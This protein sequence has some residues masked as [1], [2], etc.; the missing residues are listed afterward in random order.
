[1]IACLTE[2]PEEGLGD[3]D[4]VSCL[5]VRADLVGDLPA[6]KVR[7]LLPRGFDGALLYTLRSRGEGGRF[8]G[9]REDRLARLTL[10]A[11]SYDFVD[12]EARVDLHADVL[13]RIAGESR[14]VSWHGASKSVGELKRRFDEMA[15]VKA[16][17]YKL[18]PACG[19]SGE[20][21]APLL[22]LRE[23]RR[24]DTIAFCTG[25]GGT[26]TR[27]VAP[28]LG[29]PLIYAAYGERAAAPGQL[30]LEKL[31]TDYGLPY[32]PEFGSVFGIVGNPVE[33][34]LS[35]RLH[36]GAYR[37][38]GLT[39]MYLPFHVESFG[40]FWLEVVEGDVFR[41]ADL[42]L[43]GLSVTAPHKAATLAVASAAS[44]LAEH[45]ESAN[46][47]TRRGDLWAAETTDPEGVLGPLRARGL[48]PSTCR[49]AV[50]GSGGAGRAAAAGFVSAGATTVVV[51]RNAERGR[52][53]AR[54]LGVDF[55]PL[56]DFDASVFDVVVNA[57]SLGYRSEDALAFRPRTLRAGSVV[58]D[59]VYHQHETAL[60]ESA[61]R[62]GLVGISGREVL[63]YQA[64]DQF[65]RM[66]GHELP[67]EL[68]A[69][70]LG[71]T[72][73]RP[74]NTGSGLSG[75]EL[76]GDAS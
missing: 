5:E 37:A 70:L 10:A 22:L 67:I 42:E 4:G 54:L 47:L 30:P 72:S 1:V 16:A 27:L 39:A 11:E 20:E 32:F 40:N 66:T 15:Q 26:W 43:D 29:A 44:P 21:V 59:M 62:H 50:V 76:S 71:L 38:L 69:E 52:Q 6:D 48:D 73:D 51:N 35:P 53:L 60:I 55:V 75:S 34:S 14:V 3:L 33:H 2:A 57:T 28:R 41:H 25:A 31:R 8:E 68:G 49:A 56:A 63:L 61:R 18:V 9:S 24:D 13:D 23:L 36:N 65:R 7:E 58:I 45:I 19:E 46:T 17:L 12:L 74:S 64:V